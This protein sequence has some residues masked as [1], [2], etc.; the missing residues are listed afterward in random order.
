MYRLVAEWVWV[1]TELHVGGDRVVRYEARQGSDLREHAHFVHLR[2]DTVQDF[3][4]ERPEHD[5]AVLDRIHDEADTWRAINTRY[6]TK[7]KTYKK[8]KRKKWSGSISTP[9][10]SWKL[11]QL[12][13]FYL[14]QEA[15]VLESLYTLRKVLTVFLESSIFTETP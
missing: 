5:G 12:T 9:Y 6:N 3:A 10:S 8:K 14:E 13:F 7:K 4:F 11:G 15:P 2:H 1:R